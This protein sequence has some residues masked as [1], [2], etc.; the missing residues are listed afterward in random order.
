M[1]EWR[2]LGTNRIGRFGQPNHNMTARIGKGL[3]LVGGTLEVWDAGHFT[4]E[5]AAEK[6]AKNAPETPDKCS[7]PK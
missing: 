7:Q 5:S 1:P 2:Q 6:A 4:P 3:Q